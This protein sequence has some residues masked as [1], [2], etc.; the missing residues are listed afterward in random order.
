MSI[1]SLNIA[2]SGLKAAQS[3]INNTASNI[4][5]ASTEGYTKKI[6]PQT[7]DFSA[8]T[9]LGVRI[10]KIVRSVD[11]SL[12]KTMVEK[13][14]TIQSLSVREKFLDRIQSFHGPSEAEQSIGATLN[15]LKE[16]FILIDAEPENP[17]LADN[18]VNQA[19]E[20]ASKF[21]EFADLIL[22]L[23]NDTQNEIKQMVLDVNTNLERIADINKQIGG[24]SGSGRSIASLLDQRD[25]AMKAVSENL[26]IS[27]FTAE[28]DKVFVMT[29]SGQVL[30]DE[31][32]REVI[33]N[34]TTLLPTSFYPGGGSA[35]IFIDSTS[36]IEITGGALSGRIGE[37]INL[38]DEILPQ[39]QAQIDE[40]AQKTAERFA[41]QGL[42]LFTDAT[43]SVP[44][45]VAPP[46]AV[47]YV[48][49]A[50]QI[51]V[52]NAVM[53]DHTL[54]RSGTNGATV[55]DG[56]SAIIRKVIDFTFGAFS[57][58]QASGTV[59]VSA[60]TIFA[61]TGLTQSAR[62]I[63]NVDIAALT[64]LDTDPNI[65]AGSQFSID[66]GSGPQV[67]TIGATDTATDL[68]N[69]INLALPGTARLNSLGQLVLE[70]TAD[71]T[72]A[73]VS[74]G[75]AGINALGH[76]F[77][78][79]TAVNPSF[80]VQ[81]GINNPVTIN[82]AP[83]DTAANLLASLNAVPDITA[84]L[85]GSGGIEI[86][87]INGGD[88]QLTN[89][90]GTPLSALGLS[91]SGVAHTA[92]RQDNL[93]PNAGVST[94]LVNFTKLVDYGQGIV[95]LQSEVHNN[96]VS[97][98]ESETI[99]FNSLEQRFLNESGVDLDQEVANLI[100]LQTAYGAA[101][102]AISVSE[103]LFNTLLDAVR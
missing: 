51:Q 53:A 100:Q 96:T 10:D 15:K 17:L 64:S 50:S 49:F 30:A 103:Q 86:T 23:R 37:L 99:F 20:T 7:A 88:I 61:S 16:D 36:G 75:A 92:F 77:G 12:V 25:I 24:L 38:R 18:V 41:G 48:G 83:T 85:N 26:D 80:T 1:Q 82:I 35:G 72:V 90:F 78:T 52:N 6:L 95:S 14:S 69:N 56:S 79:T 93:G 98:L 39:Y 22:Q 27:F 101:A 58:Q 63:G 84:T 40:L 57:S 65:T 5:N 102:R 94:Q 62:V 32:A 76:N 42:A 44:P 46:A 97:K 4:S 47:G 70:A 19:V 34:P 87:P 60:G 28:N 43:G 21:N 81:A 71:I 45:S 74:L 13:G 66:I 11:L 8:D 55:P 54:V 89:T 2:L 73:D 67:I 31:N 9:P 33:F 29:A 68:V 59:D 91:I 3:A